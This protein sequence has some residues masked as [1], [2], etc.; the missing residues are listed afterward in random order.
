MLH[1]T[2]KGVH[3]RRR[4]RRRLRN[5][6]PP[7]T[8]ASTVHPASGAYHVGDFACVCRCPICVRVSGINC[9]IQIGRRGPS[10]VGQLSAAAVGGFFFS[11]NA[12]KSVGFVWLCG[13]RRRRSVN[14]R[15]VRPFVSGA[16][17]DGD[18]RGLP[19]SPEP[20]AAPPRNRISKRRFVQLP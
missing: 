17:V 5:T 14:A 9:N 2:S 4:R 11:A 1:S 18:V 16:D 19:G 8:A 6:Q 20:I 12:I 13:G 15:C 7:P 10:A 3:H